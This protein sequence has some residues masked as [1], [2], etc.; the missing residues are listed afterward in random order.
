MG[1]LIK[2]P[3][4][5]KLNRGDFA[6]RQFMTEGYG[7]A[8]QSG[9]APSSISSH[10]ALYH[11]PEIANSL[12]AEVG[13]ADDGFFYY[14]GAHRQGDPKFKRNP[15]VDPFENPYNKVILT[16]WQRGRALHL[17]HGERMLKMSQRHYRYVESLVLDD[18]LETTS[19]E[20]W[21]VP[22]FRLAPVDMVTHKPGTLPCPGRRNQVSVVPVE[23]HEL[24]CSRSGISS[25]STL[26][27][28]ARL[29]KRLCLF[30]M[31]QGHPV[32]RLQIRHTKDC[33]PLFTDVWVG[34]ANLLIEA[35]ASA[36]RNDIRQAIGQLADYTRFL[37][38]A[39]R[40]IL[41]PSRPEKDL[42]KLAHSQ[43]AALIWPSGEHCWESSAMWLSA[44]G[45][46]FQAVNR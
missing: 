42:V 45:F 20:G 38:N 25:L 24:M 30:L 11:V 43:R 40:A 13:W 16:A 10:V 14:V 21:P 17:M 27:P 33:S 29:E 32:S 31:R 22:I 3:E 28:E 12:E 26:R 44:F 15:S 35:K 41:L 37:D 9:I 19:P 5:W 34:S 18:V 1:L 46:S 23:R 36:G 7:M 6:T 8:L 2:N 39:N 4:E